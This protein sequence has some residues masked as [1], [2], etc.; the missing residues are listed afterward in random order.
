[1]SQ[2][3]YSINFIS[4]IIFVY[5]IILKTLI[6]DIAPFFLQNLEFLFKEFPILHNIY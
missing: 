4:L 2:L 1:M 5:F 6:L 3:V